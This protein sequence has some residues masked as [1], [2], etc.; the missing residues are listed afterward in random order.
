MTYKVRLSEEH[1]ALGDKI[2]KLT[3]FL[4]TPGFEDLHEVDR[5]L[6]RAQLAHMRH[7]IYVLEERM[8]RAQVEHTKVP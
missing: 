4:P 3:A 8:D 6:L 1:T 7:Y 5:T 2:T